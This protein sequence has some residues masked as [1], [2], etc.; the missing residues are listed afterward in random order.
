MK[1]K[2]QDIARFTGSARTYPGLRKFWRENMET[3]HTESSQYLYLVDALSEDVNKKISMVAK[4]TQQIWNKL[5]ELNGREE[6]LGEMVMRDIY[7]LNTAITQT[8]P[9]PLF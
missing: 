3:A 5:D 6:L 2:A 8:L 7:D 4:N 1:L 9:Q